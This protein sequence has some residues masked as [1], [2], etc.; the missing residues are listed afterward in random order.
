MGTKGG[1]GRA[2]LV[3]GVLHKAALRSKGLAQTRQ[4]CVEGAHQRHDLF[5]HA[6]HADGAQ[7]AVV[8]LGHLVGH[9]AQ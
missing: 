3:G 5:G 9:R 7:A 1:H 6:V 4:Q 8:A 2:Q